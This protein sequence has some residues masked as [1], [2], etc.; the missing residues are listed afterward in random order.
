MRASWAN[1]L[2]RTFR[3]KRREVA[4]GSVTAWGCYPRGWHKKQGCVTLLCN[5]ISY[6]SISH[7][8]ELHSPVCVLENTSVI[9]LLKSDIEIMN[10]LVV[11]NPAKAFSL[12]R[13]TVYCTNVFIRCNVEK[14]PSFSTVNSESIALV[15][16]SWTVSEELFRGFFSW[17]TLTKQL[18][19]MLFID[20]PLNIRPVVLFSVSSFEALY[21]LQQLIPNI[22]L[23][24]T[25]W[26]SN[27]QASKAEQQTGV[28]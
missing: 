21:K 12:S 16:R 22:S 19:L 8:V 18:H 4:G 15:F 2:G 27:F 3:H 5:K 25:Y 13:P 11:D 10:C 23:G 28:S 9:S 14:H 26:N 24:M 20:H 6:L 1:L 7:V 17:E